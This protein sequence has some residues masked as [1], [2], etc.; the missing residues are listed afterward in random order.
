MVHELLVKPEASARVKSSLFL[1]EC[2]CLITDNTAIILRL[3]GVLSLQC[4]NCEQKPCPNGP[5][6]F[7]GTIG[8]VDPLKPI[9]SSRLKGYGCSAR[10]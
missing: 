1:L 6:V 7:T 4:G 8:E 2:P 10:G 3:L 9:S 5:V